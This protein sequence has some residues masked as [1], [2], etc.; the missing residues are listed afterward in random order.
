MYSSHIIYARGI[1]SVTW[2]A[3]LLIY[4]SQIISFNKLVS[5]L[6]YKIQIYLRERELLRSRDKG[7]AYAERKFSDLE[8]SLIISNVSDRL[9]KS[10]PQMVC[11]RRRRSS[12]GYIMAHYC[13]GVI[14][15][16]TEILFAVILKNLRGFRFT[17][18]IRGKL[19]EKKALHQRQLGMDLSLKV[20]IK[21]L[22]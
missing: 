3:G 13:Q 14:G 20:M 17:K 2:Q 11:L 5:I 10:F 15:Y 19:I 9:M 1:K 7:N 22:T 4:L 18:G 8:Y 12:F 6:R 16:Y 21:Y